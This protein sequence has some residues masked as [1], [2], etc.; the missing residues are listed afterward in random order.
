[1]GQL[2]FNNVD[3]YYHNRPEAIIL[4]NLQLK[5]EPSRLPAY[6]CST[7]FFLSCFF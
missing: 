7:Q 2:E 6:L 1:M 5:I 3:F 4:Q